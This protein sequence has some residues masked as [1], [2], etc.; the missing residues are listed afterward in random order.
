MKHKKDDCFKCIKTA[1]AK[2]NKSKLNMSNTVRKG[3]I[4]RNE[5]MRVVDRELKDIW[6]ENKIK[7]R[8]EAE[9][10]NE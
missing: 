6:N 8:S 3:T 4:V 9:M 2:L 10:G 5:F 1:R 7:K